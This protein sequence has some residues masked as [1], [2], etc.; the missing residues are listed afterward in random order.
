MADQLLDQL[1]DVVEG[2]IDFEGQK[3]AERIVNFALSLVGAIAFLAGWLL[4]DI[5]LAV[6]LG[7][8][9]TA[10]VF[11]IVVPPWPFFNKNPINWLPVAVVAPPVN[12]VID[13]KMLK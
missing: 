6:Y 8:V 12:L 2:K 11:L 1:R 13:E 9:G 3:L 5:K 4:Q 10:A 7:L